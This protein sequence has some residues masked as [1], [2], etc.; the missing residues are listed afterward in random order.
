MCKEM[1]NNFNNLKGVNNGDIQKIVS[2]LKEKFSMNKHADMVT[3]SNQFLNT[4]R[5]RS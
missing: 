5:A 3:V 4:T 1:S 2:W